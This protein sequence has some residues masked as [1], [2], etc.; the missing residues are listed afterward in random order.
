MKFH[1]FAIAAILAFTLAAPAQQK[2]A[3]QGKRV[4]LVAALSSQ[5]APVDAQIQHHFESL[6]M[7]VNMVGDTDPP[8]AT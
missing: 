7:T 8:P 6:G 5:T 2:S 4:L 3:F 1:Q